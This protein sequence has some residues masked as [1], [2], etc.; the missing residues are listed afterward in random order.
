MLGRQI[1]VYGLGPVQYA[2][3]SPR[4]FQVKLVNEEAGPK[5]KVRKVS[6]RTLDLD[7]RAVLLTL[8]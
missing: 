5:R 8:T 1:V 2:F 3:A 4:L 6:T 7:E